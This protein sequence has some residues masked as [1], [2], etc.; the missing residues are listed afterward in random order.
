MADP[1]TRAFESIKSF[2]GTAQDNSRDWCDR[3]EIIFNALNINDGDRLARIAIKFE[4]TAFDWYRDNPGLYTTWLA[5]REAFQRAFP[6]PERTQNRHL[7]SEQINQRK[8]GPDES[9]HD[10]YYS[11]DKLCREYDP[12]MPPIDKTIKLVCGLRDELKEKI[13]PL[14]VQTP[15]EFMTHAKNFESSE[16]VMAQHRQ[17]NASI[18][19]PDPTYYFESNGYS[20]VAAT[21]PHPQPYYQQYRQNNYQQHQPNYQQQHQPNYQQQHR[22]NFQ[23]NYQQQHRQNFQQNYQQQQQQK[24][25][26]I[27]HQNYYGSY[28]QQPPQATTYIPP[29]QQNNGQMI[30]NS[31][32]RNINNYQNNDYRNCF[33]CGQKGTVDDGAV[34]NNK[35]NPSTPLIV[36]LHVN[37]KLINAM[38]DT[39]SANSIIHIKTLRKLIHQPHIIYQKN[40][41]R[42]ANNSELNTI[43]LVK[44][45]IYIKNI[46]TFVLAEV[47]VHLCTGLILGNDWITQNC[48]DI[49]TSEKCIRK[50]YGKYTIIAPFSNYDQEKYFVLPIHPVH[51]LPEQ[52][53]IIPARVKIKNADTI[54]FTPAEDFIKKKRILIP[55]TSLK[56]ENGI[57]WIT[58]MNANKVPQYLNRKMIL[59]TVS[60]PT[61]SSISLPLLP[62]KQVETVKP[63]ELKCRICY[64]EFL[65]KKELFNHLYKAGHYSSIDI[66][67]STQQLSPVVHENIKRL[68]EHIPNARDNK[69]VELI[70]IKYGEIFDTSKATTIKTTV[71]HTIEVKNTRPIVQ[72]PYRKTAAQEKI[73]EE[74]CEQFYRDNIIRPSQSSWASPVVLQKKK[75]NTW[76]FC[77]DYRKLNE[78]TEKD[79]YPL[80]RIQEIFDTLNG[81]KYFSKLDFH[82]GY[83]QIPID[84]LDKPKTAFVTRDKFW[85]YNV[86][87]QGI[88]NGPPTF[89]RI[90]NKLLGRL[91]WHCALAYI[92]DIIIYSKSKSDHLHHLEQVLSLL[93]DANFRLNAAKCEFLQKKIKFL[94]HVIN[95]DGIAP[96]PD[97][98]RAIN[99]IPTPSNVK[100]ATSFIKMAEYYRNH[101]PNFS[102]LAQPLFDLT[103]KD[104]KFIWNVEQQNSFDKI[105]QLLTSNVLLQFPDSDTPFVIQVDASN[106]GIG[107]AL[108]Q[109]HGK[110]EQPVA[111]M[112]QKLNKQQQNWSATEKECFA[113]ISSIRK[114]DHYISGREFIVRTDHHALCWLNRKYN[115]NPK[116]NRWRMAL[117][118]YTFRIEHVKGKINCVADCLSR[119][120]VNPPCDD[121]EIE[122]RSVSI[123]TEIQQ[124][125][126][127][128]VTTRRMHQRSLELPDL[129]QTAAEPIHQLIDPTLTTAQHVQQSVDQI[130]ITEKPVQE[131]ID[132]TSTAVK[133]V[134]HSIDPISTTAENFQQSP[135]MESSQQINLSNR[136]NEIKV[137]TNEELK[138][139]QQQDVSIRKI[140]EDIRKKPFSSEYCL[141]NGILHRNINRFNG[142]RKVPVVPKIKVK[143]I[144]LAYHNSSMNGAHFGK[145]R[146]YYKIRE[147]F[148][149]PRMYQDVAQHIKSC[150][151]CSINKVSRRKPN[152]HLNPINPPQG[153][154]E[155]LAMDFM[156]PITPPSSSGNK[157]ILVI[158]DLLSKFVVA[159]AT[160]D[161]SALSAA[162]VL[163]EDVILKYGTPN[164]ILT[165]NGTHFTA[166][167]FNSITSLHGICHVYTTP[168]NPQSNGTC[169][170]F[171]SSMCNSLAA[172]CNNKRTDWDQQ[173]SKLIFAYNTSR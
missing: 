123:Q 51:I 124:S 88:K 68:V 5:F 107:A 155:N 165:D 92:D 77:I 63:L 83:H 79:N 30:R 119:Y 132:S 93:H 25:Q 38:V 50:H 158:T 85:E 72:R 164:Q 116:L 37:H 161:N 101:I 58:V 144:L 34:P 10:Y 148:Y 112:S 16:K 151:N 36:S 131:L 52:E 84:E 115:N 149:W 170:R 134:Q 22:Q 111:F 74:M 137:F 32:S 7:L 102:M 150:P 78:V 121:D 8:Q 169:E 48:I 118:D 89:Q 171:N 143:D 82:G 71:K 75:D 9:V 145:D 91:Q 86:M 130:P 135:T 105:K 95:E 162:K 60:F 73:I 31:K 4:D 128:A 152:G 3:A 98:V 146:T 113:V 126:V 153:V 53:M 65:S 136:T 2:H 129:K 23:Q 166:E 20:T 97:K 133:P 56:I 172:M 45:K 125:I 157:Y 139:Y 110:G 80:P 160:R 142:I 94:G 44:L 26:Q 100:A 11:L 141:I 117:Q 90:V 163:V 6:P 64:V 55:H 21:Q 96:C 46:P 15:E 41:H 24:H 173:L 66:N 87:P 154:W 57:T 114:W 59:G 35:K 99:E 28:A 17:Q 43:G 39:G 140:L 33:K 69:E 54:V 13:L 12:K 1:V 40:V 19:L 103:K 147:R 109:D 61:P 49:I 70:L 168:Y 67:G 156:G 167:L 14:N 27:N 127:G 81:S 29:F 18:E 42:T 62:T 159:K 120:P 47:A 106:F 108:M 138:H 122:Q 104:A 76:R